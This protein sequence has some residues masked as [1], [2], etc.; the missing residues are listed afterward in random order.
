MCACFSSVVFFLSSLI[1]SGVIRSGHGRAPLN[2]RWISNNVTIGRHPTTSF[3]AQPLMNSWLSHYCIPY[4]VSK[5]ERKPKRE[6]QVMMCTGL[7]CSHIR[8]G[9]PLCDGLFPR[10]FLFFF[11]VLYIFFDISMTSYISY[12]IM[13]FLSVLLFLRS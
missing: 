3:S 13:G 5:I 2:H 4:L 12:V 10:Q 1:L 6:K 8:D 7:R 9:S 11:P